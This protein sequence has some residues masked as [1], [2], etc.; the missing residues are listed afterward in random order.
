MKV[1]VRMEGGLGDHLCANRFV[2][3]ILEKYPEAQVTAYSDTEGKEFQKE[4]LESLYPDFYKEIK[5]IP[6]RKHKKVI[7]KSDMGTENYP[8]HL[9]NI[10]DEYLIE[11]KSADKFY[12]LQVDSF[13]IE[14]QN[15][16]FDW[17]RYFCFFPRPTAKITPPTFVPE[18]N[19]VIVFQLD[20]SASTNVNNL[21]P[22][23]CENLVAPLAKQE[24]R[25]GLSP[26]CYIIAKDPESDFYSWVKNHDNVELISGSIKHMAHHISQANL[27]VGVASGFQFIAHSLGVPTLLLS[28]A[29]MSPNSCAPSFYIRWLMWPS[30]CYPLNVQ[31][32]T[33]HKAA[34]GILKEKILGLI[35]QASEMQNHH[36]Q[37]I[38]RNN[39]SIEQE[40]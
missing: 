5:V 40:Q 39:I 27:F 12:D 25:H 20:S 13:P 33:I 19:D 31:P 1:A 8:A 7:I 29:S 21:D 35:P 38:V 28:H 2:A 9:E 11:M 4:A 23:H 6:N 36:Q 24:T 22:K 3:A 37:L 17:F 14:Y 32:Q 30:V 18:P 26:R 16:D 15:Y 34:R 10:P